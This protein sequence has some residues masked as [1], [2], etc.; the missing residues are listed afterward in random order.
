[1]KTVSFDFDYTLWDEDEQSFIPETL[2]LLREHLSH[3]DRVIIVTAREGKWVEECHRLLERVNL[4]LEI[5]SAPCCATGLTDDIGLTKS[6][7]LIAEGASVHFDDLH[8]AKELLEAGRQ[9]IEVKAPP[10]TRAYIAR[11]Y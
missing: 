4:K 10:C 2:S 5:F 11:M 6:E 9:G 1:V 7:V 3:G 8:D